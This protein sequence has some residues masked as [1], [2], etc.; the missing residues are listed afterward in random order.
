MISTQPRQRTRF[1][2]AVAATTTKVTVIPVVTTAPSRDTDCIVLTCGLQMTC[3]GKPHWLM[4]ATV[5]FLWCNHLP[6]CLQKRC[7]GNTAPL[8]Q[9][10]RM[11]TAMTATTTTRNRNDWCV[12]YCRHCISIWIW[13][14]AICR[15]SW[16]ILV[17]VY[18]TSVSEIMILSIVSKAS[19]T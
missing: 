1:G 18:T 11:S 9:S 13:S 4:T 19:Y 3:L 8:L 12:I 15:D 17:L 7:C 5:C 16:T 10:N 6:T 2:A 14:I